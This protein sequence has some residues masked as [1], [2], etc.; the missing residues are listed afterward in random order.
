MK[1]L[2]FLFIIAL[3][4]SAGKVTA[5]CVTAGGAMA[6]ICQGGTSAALGG[7]FGGAADSAK[8]SDGGAGGIFTNNAG[9]HPDAATYTASLSASG[10]ITLTLTAYGDTCSG[11]TVSKQITVN[12]LPAAYNQTPIVCEDSYGSG[13]ASGVN[14]TLLE[15]SV[16]GGAANTT[17][18]WY[19][20]AGHTTT[21]STPSSVTV[22]NSLV[23]YPMVTNTLTGCFSYATVTYTVNP[24]PVASAVQITGTLSQGASLAAG[25]TYVT[26]A[27]SAEV[28]SKTEITWYVADDN[29]GTNSSWVATKPGTDKSFLLTAADGGK[30]LQVCVRV[31]DGSVPL[32]PSVC[33][34]GWYGPVALNTAPVASNA[35]VTGTAKVASI[36]SGHYTYQDAESDPEGSSVYRWYT[37][38]NSSGAGAALISG[39]NSQFY[40]LTNN[41]FGKYVGFSV[42]PVALSGTTTGLTDTTATWAGPVINPPPVASSPVVVGT[43]N[44]GDALTGQYVYSDGEGDIENGSIYQWSSSNTLGGTYSFIIGDT[45][46]THVIQM[47]EQGM[48][49]KFFVIPK[50]LTGSTTGT[51]VTSAGFGPA[52]TW[53]SA[54]SVNI[55]GSPVQV[56]TTLEAT[57]TYY[58]PDG[59]PKGATQF[60][61]FRDGVP[62]T[63]GTD[64]TYLLTVA[65]GGATMGVEVTPVSATGYPNTGDP[66]TY[67]MSTTVNDPSTK[68]VANNVCIDGKRILGS[69]LS[70]RYQYTYAPKPEGTS[71]YKWYR[72]GVAIP[73]ATSVNYTVTTNDLESD[74]IFEVTPRSSNST[75]KV[76]DPAQSHSLARITMT[77]DNF[78]AT[79]RDTILTA[80]PP[81]G[82]FWGK[83]VIN[84]KFSPKSVDYTVNPDTVNYHLTDYTCAQ[85]AVSYITVNGVTAYFQ[86]FNSFY[87]QNGGYDTIMVRNIPS[88]YVYR[89][90]YITNGNAYVSQ[91]NDS[92]IVIDPSQLAA[93]KDQDWLYFYAFDYYFTTY[94]QLQ[95]SFD[96]EAIRPI[97]ISGVQNNEVFCNNDPKQELLVNQPGGSFTGPVSGGFLDPSLTTG[98][99][100]VTYSYTSPRGCVSS[101]TV[102]ITINPVPVVSFASADSCITSVNDPTLFINY[103]TSQDSVKQWYWLFYDGGSII[104]DSLHKEPYYTYTTGGFHKITLKATTVNN[105]SATDVE[106]IEM[107]FKP[108]ADFRWENEC[109]HQ[110]DSIYLFDSTLTTT[111]IISRTWN[112][113]DGDS[114]HV[115][116]NPH[117]PQKA[118]GYLNVEYIVNTKFRGCSDTARKSIYIRPTISLAKD[119]Y[120]ENFEN[121]NGSWVKNYDTL[122]TWAFG[123][124]D[125]TVINKAASGNNAW[126]TDF[127]PVNQKAESSSIVSPCFNFDSI[128]RPMISMKLWT[129]FNKNRDGAALQYRIRDTKVGDKEDWEYVGTLDD[130]IYWYNSSLIKGRPGGDQ[131]GWTT[132]TQLDKEWSEARHKLDDLVGKKDVKFRVA[133]GS[134]GTSLDNDGIAFDDVMIGRRTRGVLLEHFTNNSSQDASTATAQ[135]SDLSNRW[136]DDIINIQYHTNFPGD[137]PYYNDNPGDASARILF[138][139]LSRSPYTFIDGGADKTNYATLFDWI[140]ASLDSND[141]NRR[142]MISPYF[143]LTLHGAVSSGVVTVSGALKALQDIDESNI[144]LYLAVTQKKSTGAAGAL[145]ET[146]YYNVFRKFIP[147]AGGIAM[148]R[149]WTKND[150]D[151]INE[152]SWVI[153]DIPA[154]ADIEII[155]FLQ[156]NITKEVYQ[157]ESVI[158]PDITV[159][160]NDVLAGKGKGFILYPNP[161]SSKLAISFENPISSV[162]D[163][164]IYDYSGTLVKTYKT[165]TGGSEY[166]ID[167]LGLSSGIYL[168]RIS[169]GGVDYGFKKLV[170]S[171]K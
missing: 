66:V 45:T 81:G 146:E 35:T 77:K 128:T 96:V 13:S 28:L 48:Y 6:A 49:F 59:D 119:D 105:C 83:G 22:T 24:K 133:Y 140:I 10:T 100:N 98:N 155:A 126:F 162:T 19:S 5:Q 67:T 149:T 80:D 36:L 11:A 25:Y 109:L 108:K 62:V 144:T 114:L 110:N 68:P 167:D 2:A 60:R 131:I 166:V 158:S 92:T 9:L 124:P 61:W 91:I 70:G 120:F 38:T 137:D 151:T 90:F 127:D 102:P 31:S 64:S 12:A 147:D 50:T 79:D 85:D 94:L 56:G 74:I 52:N 37:G 138:Y 122:N 89:Y 18:T 152:K 71:W 163:I 43:K 157:A 129:S 3:S 156:N 130:G 46:L 57:F 82:Y 161:A 51:K 16:T 115:R 142:S 168:V 117:Y 29:T 7:S 65:D 141:V 111:N 21:V 143:R 40:Q 97:T 118:V 41:E 165:G 171:E 101:L 116:L 39:A 113:N 17:V 93:A 169:S 55:T 84:G 73:G 8:W 53:P 72:D 47:S 106:T 123:T 23:F 26:G 1:R 154:G 121:G 42:T 34:T 20:N 132:G 33:S 145:G 87:C 69:V 54:S 27:C 112:F 99:A 58:D 86:G 95:Q 164:K 104:P 159:G 170:V 4:L 76:G 103:T 88:I 30:Y 63:V 150:T 14:L 139:G 148:K 32:A 136:P 78:I 153:S 44:V 134:D 160:I 15:S 107:G 135:V 125:R 75:P